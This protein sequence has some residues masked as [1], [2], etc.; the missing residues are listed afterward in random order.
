MIFRSVCAMSLF[1][2]VWLQAERTTH[3][4]TYSDEEYDSAEDGDNE[5]P[6]IAAAGGASSSELGQ[7]PNKKLKSKSQPSSKYRF[8]SAPPI[9]LGAQK[10]P[11]VKIDIYFFVTPLGLL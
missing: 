2:V 8:S 4:T 10:T 5:G 9:S 11:R 7:K 1:V 3:G 6:P